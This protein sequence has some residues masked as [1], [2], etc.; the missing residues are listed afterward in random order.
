MMRR[1]AASLER[2]I[3]PALSSLH[4]K[5]T[6]RSVSD[7]ATDSSFTVPTVKV[8]LRSGAMPVRWSA[9]TEALGS[10]TCAAID[11]GDVRGVEVVGVDQCE[12][13]NPEPPQLLGNHR[14]C[15]SATDDA[16]GERGNGG[17]HRSS[18]GADV[19]RE[20]LAA[21]GTP[22]LSGV[23]WAILLCDDGELIAGHGDPI[24]WKLTQ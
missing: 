24:E 11:P 10:R 5:T 8:T 2:M 18:E 20:H 13:R 17:L 15:S 22:F 14:P 4:P 7:R 23:A 21:N 3:R 19:S 12:V 1:Y 6:S 16:D 9:S